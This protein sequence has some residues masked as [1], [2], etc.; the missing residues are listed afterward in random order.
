MNMLSDIVAKQ[1]RLVVPVGEDPLTCLPSF[2]HVGGSWP[3]A[4]SRHTLGALYGT[5]GTG[6]GMEKPLTVDY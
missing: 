6:T 3:L 2:K 4:T 1:W 5:S